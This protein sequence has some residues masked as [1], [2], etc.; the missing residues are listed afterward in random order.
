MDGHRGY[1]AKGDKSDREERLLYNFTCM[2]N[3][4]HKIN[5]QNG[6][7]VQDTEN[8]GLRMGVGLGTV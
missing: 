5:K 8:R 4:K 6:N 7:K 3:L 2:W 1:Y